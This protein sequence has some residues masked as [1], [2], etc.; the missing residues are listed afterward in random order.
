MAR[1]VR[2]R[3]CALGYSRSR[4]TVPAFAE[5]ACAECARCTRP[6]S[7]TRSMTQH[8]ASRGT[9]SRT[10]AAK[11]SFTSSEE[12]SRSLASVRNFMRRSA[13][14]ATARACTSRF[15]S[16][17]RSISA[18]PSGRLVLTAASTTRPAP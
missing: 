15:S 4:S 7:S 9:M 1:R 13:A 14:S 8:D 16:V 11:V 5:S 6:D 2:Y 3:D 18:R 17:S 12:W 10:S